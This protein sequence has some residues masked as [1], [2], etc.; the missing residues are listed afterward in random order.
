MLRIGIDLGGTKTEAAVMDAAGRLLVRERIAT[1]RDYAGTIDAIAEIIDD[2][3][4]R[5]GPARIGLGHPGSIS[6]KTG[7]MRNAN[8]VWL[9]GSPFKTDLEA[10]L[11]REVR[12]ANDADC[13]ALSEARNGAGAGESVVFGVILGTGVGGGIVINGQLLTG[14]QHIAGEWGHNALPWPKP[15]EL[16]G[17]TCWCG[18]SGCIET[19]LSG[20]GMAREHAERTGIAREPRDIL[21]ASDAAS[22]DSRG[23]Y[24]DRLT[25]ALASVVNIIDPDVIVLG[26]GL[27]NTQDLPQKVEEGLPRYVFSDILETRVRR[28]MHGDSSGV[29]GAAWL[30]PAAPE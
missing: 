2:L 9:N 1:P 25:R 28:H 29:R 12:M 13:F 15:G 23:R 6:P 5:H 22:R 27:S 16:P 18:Q 4:G 14:A 17:T 24:I 21:A 19:W 26:G 20:P 3:E 30:W 8:S 11:G 7:N 10:R